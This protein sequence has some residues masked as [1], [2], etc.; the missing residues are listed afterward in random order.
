TGTRAALGRGFRL[1]P[2]PRPVEMELDVPGGWSWVSP[3]VTSAGCVSVP[4]RFEFHLEQGGWQGSTLVEME[5]D[6][7]GRWSRVSPSVTSAGCVS[8]PGRFEF[9]L[10]PGGWQ[11]STPV[12]MELDVPRGWPRV[13]PSGPFA[14]CVSGRGVRVPSRIR[15]VAAQHARRDGA[16]R[17]RVVA[18]SQPLGAF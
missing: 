4:G 15:R 6:V 1:T 9:H 18:P 7:P 12:E 5:L 2:E 11:H 8:V 14:G 17:S 3:S 13:S 16:R 10:E